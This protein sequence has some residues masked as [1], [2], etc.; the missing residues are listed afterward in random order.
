[1]IFADRHLA[2]GDLAG[3]DVPTVEVSG[4]AIESRRIEAGGN[5]LQI[6]E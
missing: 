2:T 5:G 6:H 3:L 1:M 4:D